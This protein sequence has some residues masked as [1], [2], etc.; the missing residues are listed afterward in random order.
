M[1]SSDHWFASPRRGT[2]TSIRSTSPASYNASNTSPAN[3]VLPAPGAADTVAAP[4][5][6][7]AAM[8]CSSA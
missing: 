1:S 3:T 2:N 4:V 7:M 8:T 5:R 6:A